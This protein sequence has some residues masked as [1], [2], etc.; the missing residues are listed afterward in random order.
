MGGG[1][2]LPVGFCSDKFGDCMGESGVWTNVKD[3]EGILPVDDATRRENDRDEVD[4]SIFE[5]GG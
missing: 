5:K 3:R 4:A 2:G 1:K